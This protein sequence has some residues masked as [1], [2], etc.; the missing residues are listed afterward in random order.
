MRIIDLMDGDTNGVQQAAALLVEGF[1][2]H[3]PHPW[4]DME[5]ALAEVRE[6]LATDRLSR[7][8]RD[9][10][11]AV[12]GWI[13]GVSQYDGH[14]WELH[15]LVVHVDHQG[16]GIGR[17]LVRDLEEQVRERGGLTM[18]LG[19]DDDHGQ[20]TLSGVNLFPDVYTHIARIQNLRH[21]PY[22]F[23]QKLGYTIVGVV[24]DA[25]GIGKP[26]IL[27]AKSLASRADS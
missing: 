9:E 20:T 12:L 26:D 19:T 8:A 15:P 24:P 18:M 16:Q 4:P 23:Y 27:M 6:S 21:H 22:A 13:G 10:N 5:T 25:S 14:V 7:V 17:A 2:D 11:G 1:R 3:S